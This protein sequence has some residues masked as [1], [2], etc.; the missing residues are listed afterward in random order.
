MIK[1]PRAILVQL[2]SEQ[3]RINALTKARRIKE[4][5]TIKADAANIITKTIADFDAHLNFC[6][7]YYY[8]DTNI[9]L[10]KNRQ[11]SGVLFTVDGKPATNTGLSDTSRDYLIAYYGYPNYQSRLDDTETNPQ[12]YSYSSNEPHGR[13]MINYLDENYYR[14]KNYGCPDP[15]YTSG[16]RDASG[17]NKEYMYGQHFGRG[18]VINNCRFQQVSFL[19]KFGYDN[20]LFSRK[21]ENRQY[22]YKSKR[23]DLEY[24]PFAEKLNAALFGLHEKIK[25]KKI[26]INH[27]GGQNIFEW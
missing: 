19:Y 27:Y 12:K 7:V 4:L 5:L 8:I 10:I 3:N 26:R 17:A 23:F 9:D 24:F 11:F 13:E 20:V 1:F 22:I 14:I 15:S 25:N 2:S 18:L 21:R 16:N 6:P